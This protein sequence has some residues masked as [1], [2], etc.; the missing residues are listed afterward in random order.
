M[1]PSLIAGVIPV[2]GNR[3]P[4]KLVNAVVVKKTAVHFSSLLL[5]SNPYI[6]TSPEAIPARLINTWIRVKVRKLMPRTIGSAPFGSDNLEGSS[7]ATLVRRKLLNSFASNPPSY[8]GQ[9]S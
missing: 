6:T 9:L 8:N 4:V 3:K 1:I 7:D 2:N 5:V